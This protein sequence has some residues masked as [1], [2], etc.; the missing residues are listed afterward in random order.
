MKFVRL[1]S[2]ASVVVLLS[3]CGG[4]G[5]GDG[6]SNDPNAPPTLVTR[7]SEASTGIAAPSRPLVYNTQSLL[8]DPDKVRLLVKSL[9]E[10]LNKAPG[11]IAGQRVAILNPNG[12]AVA[13]AFACT[14]GQIEY[15]TPPTTSLSYS[16]QACFDGT[17]TYTGGATRTPP[18]GSP[19]VIDY[20]TASITVTGAGAPTTPITGRTSCTAGGGTPQC[21]TTQGPVAGAVAAG[22]T[23]T[24]AA[25]VANGTYQCDCFAES[26]VTTPVTMTVL[27]DA[28]GPTSGKAY[29]YASDGAVYVNRLGA[30]TYDV[31]VGLTGT[32]GTWYRN[33]TPL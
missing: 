6:G 30:N 10:L 15:A 14:T 9:G 2:I 25:G 29:V 3:A 5:G 16:Y 13:G 12:S 11:L 24:L 7:P 21:V 31:W 18:T 28:F 19:Y 20:S 23:A 4:G 1:A 27:F 22:Y 32:S 8:T 26:T 17:F 33:V